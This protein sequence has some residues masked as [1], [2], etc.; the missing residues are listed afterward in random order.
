MEAEADRV[1]E[2]IDS[3]EDVGGA[4]FREWERELD[5][6]TDPTL[7]SRSERQYRTTRARFDRVVEAMNRAAGRMDPVLDI[8]RDQVLFLKHNLNARAIASLDEEQVEI[9]ERVEALIREMDLAI[10]EANNFIDQMGAM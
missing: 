4:L 10:A 1:R 9:A 3:I 7:R 6:Y 2:R 5:A 8:Y